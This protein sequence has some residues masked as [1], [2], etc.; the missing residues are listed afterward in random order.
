[1]KSFIPLFFISTL[2]LI[3]TK[4]HADGGIVNGEIRFEQMGI[5]TVEAS[6]ILY[7][8]AELTDYNRDSISI[9]WGDGMQGTI[10]RVNGLDSDGNGVPDGEMISD[11]F[12]KH[13]Y[14]GLHTYP[15]LGVYVISH[16]APGRNSGIININYPNSD[17]IPLYFS[18]TVTLQEDYN[19]NHSPV[20]LEPPVDYGYT[21]HP[22]LH[23][24]NAFDID[25][26]S[27]VYDLIIPLVDQNEVVP[28]YR[29]PSTMPPGVNNY[30]YL[31]AET[32]LLVWDAPQIPGLY[33]IAIRVKSYRNGALVDQVIRDMKISIQAADDF[34]PGITLSTIE[35]E[36]QEVHP[37]DVVEVNVTAQCF[38]MAQALT[39]SSSSGL[40]DY[41]GNTASFVATV[42]GDEGT[43]V[44]AWTVQ[45][46]QV[47]SQPYTIVFKAKDD[48]SEYGYANFK[49]I[50]YKVTS[51]AVNSLSDNDFG[52]QWKV[53]P[54]P[55]SD[56][57]T[58]E[59]SGNESYR[60]E[61]VDML[62]RVAQS[63]NCSMHQNSISLVQLPS[64]QYLLQITDNKG[65]TKQEKIIKR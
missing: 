5:N 36:V 31:D 6:I 4:T 17:Q 53:Y 43:G 34:Y 44:F 35:N 41:F 22:F 54:N 37:G 28:F 19:H 11:R 48:F 51:S 39:L 33:N 14:R 55:A 46:E 59:L 26:D 27:I 50:R 58:M 56:L 49:L 42:S 30:F 23:A 25:D 32:G 12:S 18:S 13:I 60:Y 61:I 40:Y 38:D 3:T 9:H 57:I 7:V 2:L 64:S 45:E 10:A 52:P 21:G 29:D 47:R 1:M 16:L 8:S 62:G 63:G 20:L 24:I 65:N 15:S